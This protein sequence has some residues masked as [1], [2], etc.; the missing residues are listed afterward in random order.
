MLALLFLPPRGRP[1]S[2]ANFDGGM[3]GFAP[4]DP[5]LNAKSIGSSLELTHEANYCLE[6]P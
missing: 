5:P 3:A 2:I 4:L 1:N 6:G